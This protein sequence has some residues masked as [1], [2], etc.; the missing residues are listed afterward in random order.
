[1]EGKTEGEE[2]RE[3]K[4]GVDKNG[5]RQKRMREV[6]IKTV[7]EVIKKEEK[8]GTWAH[9]HLLTSYT[10]NDCWPA[11]DHHTAERKCIICMCKCKDSASFFT[12]MLQ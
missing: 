2:R 3:K 7:Q 8:N 5:M 12:V 4:G 6:Q 11:H 9:E 10:F 1:M